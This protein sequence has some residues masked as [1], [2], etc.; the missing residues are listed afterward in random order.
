M[1]NTIAY[2]D[3]KNE[4]TSFSQ[5]G[6]EDSSVSS[7]KYAIWIYIGLLLFEGALRKWI[8]PTLSG[9]LLLVR[10]PIAIYILYLSIKKGFLYAHKYVLLTWLIGYISFIATMISGHGNWSV[11]I[12]GLRILWI[13]FPLLFIIGKVFDR[14]DVVLLGKLLLYVSIPMT[15]LM[16]IQFYSPQSAW[17]NRGVGGNEAGGGFDG[18]MGFFRP[19]GTFS[20]INGL[21]L[22]Y[23][24][25]AAYI[26]YFWLSSKD[27]V[28]KKTLILATICLM[29]AV[30]LSI[31]RTLLLMVGICAFFALI[32]AAF[33]AKYLPKIV[34]A[35]VGLSVL[36]MAL[37]NVGFF[38]TA[39]EAFSVRMET[40]G[41]VEGGAKGIF[42]DR[43]L[44]GMLNSLSDTG[45]LPFFGLGLGMGTNAGTQLLTGGVNEYLIDEG[46][47]GR[48]IGE[49][50]FL[51][52]LAAIIIRLVLIGEFAVKTFKCVRAGDFLP[53][54]LF[55][56]GFMLI[57][58]GQW[59]QPTSLGF[60]VLIGGLIIAS[61][62]KR[63]DE[64][65]QYF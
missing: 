55:G 19:P 16:T 24:L 51:F 65:I 41:A 33:N 48:L 9:P 31:S 56:N 29:A 40:A 63:P 22:F 27:L 21:F 36:F 57:L 2:A 47:W 6:N 32:A 45:K 25:T 30:P 28:N 12:F 44:G 4:K 43:F 46:E 8:L 37:S 5:S 50:G 49:M 59:G 34:L 23:G 18:A 3:Q 54:L 39:L 61:Y 17:I 64:T 60:S 42:L 35:M 52:G 15:V 1:L 20:F 14:K 58:Q 53:W 7:I 26:F 13:Q 38:K 11:A 10:E 62:K